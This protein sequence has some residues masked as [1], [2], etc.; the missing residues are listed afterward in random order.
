MQQSQLFVAL[1]TPSMVLRYAAAFFFVL[2]AIGLVY[3][4]IRLGRTLGQAEQLLGDVNGEVVPLLKQATETLDNVNEELQKLDTVMGT[5][6]DVTEKVDAT[7]R[8]MEAAVSMPAKKAAA[9]GAGVSQAFSSMIGRRDHAS[10]EPP[11]SW[12]D[13]G[14]AWRRS[15]TDQ[16]GGDEPRESA[17]AWEPK[18]ESQA[19]EATSATGTVAPPVEPDSSGPSTEAGGEAAGA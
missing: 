15:A 10:D 4:L 3:A 17:P 7:T 6:V 8:A 5:V 9:W 16:G 19:E 13:E 14:A 11:A 12:G 2:V 1:G 18:T